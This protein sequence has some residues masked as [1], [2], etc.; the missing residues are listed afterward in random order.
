[1]R[2]F[3]IEIGRRVDGGGAYLAPS[4]LITHLHIV[5]LSRS[6]KSMWLFWLIQQ[7]IRL[8]KPMIIIDPHGSLY[9]DIL[10]YLVGRLIGRATV[11]FDP[12]YEARIVGF[13]PFQTPYL[14]EARKMTKAERLSQQLLRVFGMDNSDQFGNIERLLRSLFFA[15]LDLGLSICDLKYFI[16]WQYEAERL[17]FISRIASELIKADL[18]DLYSTKA[19]FERKIG[20]TKNKLQR[21]I[22][23]QMRRIMGLKDNNIS[24]A[25]VI[26]NKQILLCNLQASESDLVGRENMK[27]L[28]TLLISELWEAFR[29]R[30][31]PQEFYLICDEMQEFMTPDLSQILPQSAKYGLHCILAHQHQGQLS[32]SL[33]V[34]IKNA[35]TKIIFSTEENPKKQRH[36]ILQRADH[37]RIEAI[38]PKIK[39]W[40]PSPASVARY[41]ENATRHFLT[42]EEVDSR[43]SPLSGKASEPETE[44]VS[45]FE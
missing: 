27:A 12:S 21:F 19:E 29:K 9:R 33:E 42:P 4:D 44:E 30:T 31:R 35:Q 22:H 13:N 11:L 26:E 38:A 36:F 5:G 34:A 32:S 25:Q 40:N 28:G 39:L 1:M 23:P 37:T 3:R 16:Y 15:I 24:L 45:P 18:T 41:V 7:L 43:L 14:D 6:G 20:S 8:R 17:E 10:N 2:N